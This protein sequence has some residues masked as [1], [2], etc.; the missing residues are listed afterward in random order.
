M[1][2]PDKTQ[3]PDTQNHFFLTIEAIA[4][5]V[6]RQRLAARSSGYF[7]QNWEILMTGNLDS[8]RSLLFEPK[9]LKYVK[10]L[11]LDQLAP[12][13]RLCEVLKTMFWIVTTIAIGVGV[14]QLH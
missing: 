10:S 11:N 5:V 1:K 8:T 9:V 7:W 14:G 6:Y 13:G 3:K 4:N 2:A 12:P